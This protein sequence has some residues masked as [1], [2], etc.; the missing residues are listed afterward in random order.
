MPIA[1]VPRYLADQDFGEASPA[2]RFGMYLKLWGVNRRSQAHLWT[3]HDVG[4]EVR[5]QQHQE[6]EVR[7]ENKV[8]ALNEARRLTKNDKKI[9]RALFDRQLAAYSSLASSSAKCQFD[10]H[11]VA[12]FTT[13]L[14]NEHPLENGFAFL[15]PYG[16]PYLPG[17][18]VK[19]V[20]RQAARELAS[21]EWGGRQGWSQDPQYPLQSE[22]KPVLDSRQARVELSAIDVLFGRETPSGE[23]D[24]VRGALAFWDVIPQ[25]EGDSLMVEIMTPHQGHYYQWKKDQRGNEIEVSPHE[26]GQPNPISFLTV[27]PGSRFVFHVQCD[28]GHLRRLAPETG[29]DGRWQTLLDAAFRHA[30]DWLGFG[31]KTAVGYGQMQR[32]GDA[33]AGS[34]GDSGGPAAGGTVSRESTRWTNVL[35]T[36]NPGSGQLTVSHRGKV[37]VATGVAAGQLRETLPPALVERLRKKKELRLAA[38]E[39]EAEGNLC[40]IVTLIPGA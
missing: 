30:F 23:S 34:G 32:A 22:G 19:G 2:M 39:V 12:P 6:R 21:G 8:S 28:V 38:V 37:A 27:P 4:Y 11:A 15:N 5:G 35:L 40:T 10:A 16:L 33:A 25:I 26:S 3:T 20:L 1:A 36:L 17:S 7:Y 31:A 24:H 29:V 18:G 9:L 13:G 14:G